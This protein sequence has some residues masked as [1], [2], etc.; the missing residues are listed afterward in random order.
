MRSIEVWE[1]VLVKKRP[2]R[3]CTVC[4]TKLASKMRA[5]AK[6]CGPKCKNAE[7]NPKRDPNDY[8]RVSPKSKST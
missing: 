8:W 6:Y 3:F 1:P 4:G 2:D 7:N 5:D